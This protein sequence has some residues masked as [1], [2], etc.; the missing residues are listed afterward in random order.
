MKL[1]FLDTCIHCRNPPAKTFLFWDCSQPVA[2][3]WVW[4][5]TPAWAWQSSHVALECP[6]NR[7]QNQLSRATSCSNP[8]GRQQKPY[9]FFFTKLCRDLGNCR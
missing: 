7:Q 8:P 1:I 5:S 9:C 2:S 3:L 6:Y 4:D